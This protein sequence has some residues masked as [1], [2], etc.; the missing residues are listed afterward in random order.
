MRV[1]ASK[2][3]PRWRKRFYRSPSI[4]RVLHPLFGN[5]IVMDSASSH[6]QWATNSS[7]R[8]MLLAKLR[9]GALCVF[10]D[11]TKEIHKVISGLPRRRE[12]TCRAE[13]VEM[14]RILTTNKLSRDLQMPCACH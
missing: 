3:L 1:F 2:T 10:S 4:R 5:Y 8:T 7:S 14:R 11:E 12:V 13:I 6:Q 9:P